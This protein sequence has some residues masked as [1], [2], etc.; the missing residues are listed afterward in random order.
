MGQQSTASPS[1]AQVVPLDLRSVLAVGALVT[2]VAATS[3]VTVVLPYYVK[4]LDALP[5]AEVAGG[6]HDPKDLWP[7]GAAGGWVQLAALLAIGL[8]PLTA[9]PGA[10]LSGVVLLRRLRRGGPARVVA[11]NALVLVVSVAV[12]VV[13]FSPF[14]SALVTWR[15][16]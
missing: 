5:L 2:A 12:L 6:G 11:A 9:V 4:D 16:D 13:Y 7:Q 1:D 15:L 14:G 8:V 3:A 10:A